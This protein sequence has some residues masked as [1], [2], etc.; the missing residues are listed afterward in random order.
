MYLYAYLQ[1][2]MYIY[3]YMGHPGAGKQ[4]SIYWWV[5]LLE[6]HGIT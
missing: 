4:P 5:E 1:K 6:D 2:Q 3:I